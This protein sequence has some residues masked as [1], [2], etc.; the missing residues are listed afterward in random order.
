MCMYSKLKKS[1]YDKHH[2]VVE[3][4]IGDKVLLSTK[5]L[6]LAGSSKLQ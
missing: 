3:F 1:Y 6:R 4:Y 2:R 5:S